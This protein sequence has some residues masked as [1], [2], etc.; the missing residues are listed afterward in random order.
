MG[1]AR[2][3]LERCAGGDQLKHYRPHILVLI[4]LAS[5]LLSGWHGAF[6]NVLA[7]LRFAW[8]QRQASGEIVVVA[9]DSLSI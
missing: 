2:P 8:D 3:W 5:V 6:R 7:D 4:A 9:I 1:A